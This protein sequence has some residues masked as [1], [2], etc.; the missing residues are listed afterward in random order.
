MNRKIKTLK[1]REKEGE[2]EGES[3]ARSSPDFSNSD[4]TFS[5]F[6]FLSLVNKLKR[7]SRRPNV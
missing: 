1:E 4:A 5:R 3:S 6:V 2:I 7:T